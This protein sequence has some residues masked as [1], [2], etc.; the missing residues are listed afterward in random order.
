VIKPKVPRHIAVLSTDSKADLFPLVL[1][2]GYGSFTISGLQLGEGTRYSK[3]VSANVYSGE[4]HEATA[5]NPNAQYLKAM[6]RWP[7]DVRNHLKGLRMIRDQREKDEDLANPKGRVEVTQII[8]SSATEAI[9][10]AQPVIHE[11]INKTRYRLIQI[12]TRLE[13]IDRCFSF[14]DGIDLEDKK[15]HT[16]ALG[17]ALCLL[18]MFVGISDRKPDNQYDRVGGSNII[19]RLF[20]FLDHSGIR[21]DGKGLAEVVDTLRDCH[22]RELSDHLM[23]GQAEL[24]TAEI[25]ADIM[26][27]VKIRRCINPKKIGAVWNV[28]KRGRIIG[29][30]FGA[31][32]RNHSNITDFTPDEL[33]QLKEE[34]YDM[35]V[36][37][38]LEEN[39][40]E[41]LDHWNEDDAPPLHDLVQ[42]DTDSEEAPTTP[43]RPRLD[44]TDPQSEIRTPANTQPDRQL[45]Q[46][47]KE[48]MEK[49]L[50]GDGEIFLRFF[51]T[52]QLAG[53]SRADFLASALRAIKSKDSWASLRT[54]AD[55]SVRAMPGFDIVSHRCPEF[56]ARWFSNPHRENAVSAWICAFQASL[57]DQDLVDD[58]PIDFDLGSPRVAD[59]ELQVGEPEPIPPPLPA[60]PANEPQQ[61]LPEVAIDRHCAYRPGCRYDEAL[62]YSVDFNCSATTRYPKVLKLYCSQIGRVG[63]STELTIHKKWLSTMRFLQPPQVVHLF[64]QSTDFPESC[65]LETSDGGTYNIVEVVV[66]SPSPGNDKFFVLNSGMELVSGVGNPMFHRIWTCSNARSAAIVPL[67]SLFAATDLKRS[68]GGQGL[69]T[70][71]GVVV[72]NLVAPSVGEKTFTGEFFF[73]NVQ[74][75]DKSL[76]NQSLLAMRLAGV[77]SVS[78][79]VFSLQVK[80]KAPSINQHP[81]IRVGQIIKAFDVTVDYTLHDK[82]P[83]CNLWVGDHPL[84]GL[85][86]EIF[87]FDKAPSD[88]TEL[89]AW[90]R[91]VLSSQKLISD[92]KRLKDVPEVSKNKGTGIDLVVEVV[93]FAGPRAFV[94]ADSHETKEVQLT[95]L[96]PRG[97]NERDSADAIMRYLIPGSWVLLKRLTVQGRGLVVRPRDVSEVPVWCKDVEDVRQARARTP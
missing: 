30:A 36:A 47:R 79:P 48:E 70:V 17:I 91:A 39:W 26:R 49:R 15:M 21:A 72:G 28:Q 58:Y 4:Y 13:E 61:I 9:N 68:S 27:F 38:G 45:I 94:V 50:W 84:G 80:S 42:S 24:G 41:E 14:F 53:C 96:S 7:S 71:A 55:A 92:K 62:S 86:I 46:I 23:F 83:F 34:M 57:E 93:G 19:G 40:W 69:V 87:D 3:K 77:T 8:C 32:F 22:R 56:L 25:K 2:G 97:D 43:K 6:H 89:A 18:K 63:R 64:L 81:W 20:K 88:L 78:V 37:N 12:E 74:I 16:N 59:T 75:V 73:T 44:S 65:D 35:V 60:E 67:T 51:R 54:T 31:R 66:S 5:A 85:N 29:P 52:T 82:R 10:L 1:E 95:V 11:A 76:M 33:A 90:G